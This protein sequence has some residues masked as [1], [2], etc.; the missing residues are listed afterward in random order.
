[1][2]G[3]AACRPL[4]H[5]QLAHCGGDAA[6]GELHDAALHPEADVAAEVGDARCGEHD[7][8]FQMSGAAVCRL[9]L[10]GEG[11][12]GVVVVGTGGVIDVVLIVA[13]G[14]R[15]G[16]GELAGS[17]IGGADGGAGIEA[18]SVPI[19]RSVVIAACHPQL[20]TRLPG[21]FQ[22]VVVVAHAGLRVVVGGGADVQHASGGVVVF[23]ADGTFFGPVIGGA[24]CGYGYPCGGK[25]CVFP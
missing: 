24:A 18:S 14:F 6:Q 7:G 17:G 13:G 2:G 11:K 20:V 23:L 16:S 22:G 19:G 10:L 15:R 8:I 4:Q 1:M 25:R 9:C 12:F 21:Q 5:L 3:Q